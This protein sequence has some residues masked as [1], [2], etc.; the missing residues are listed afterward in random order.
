QNYGISGTTLIHSLLDGHPQ[1]LTLPGLY[2]MEAY[3]VWKN[4][5]GQTEEVE[6]AQYDVL[7]NHFVTTRRHWFDLQSCPHGLDRLGEE[8]DIRLQIPQEFFLQTM[9]AYCGDAERV[10]R[11]DFVVSLFCVFNAHYHRSVADH[12]LLV[13]P[14]HSQPKANMALLRADFS[15]I[16][17]LHMVREPVQNIGSLIKHVTV[18]TPETRFTFAKGLLNCAFWQVLMEKS[19]HWSKKGIRVYGKMPY[20]PDAPHFESRALKLE[21]IHLHSRESMEAL[22]RWLHLDWNDSLLKSE[23]MGY[24]WHNRPESVEQRGLGTKTISQ[25][26]DKYLN[27]F[28]KWRLDLFALKERRY[29]D[30]I[31]DREYNAQWRYLFPLFILLWW[32]FKAEVLKSR[33]QQQC[34][35]GANK[36]K[37]PTIVMAFTVVCRNLLNYVSLRAAMLSKIINILF[38]DEE[39]QYVA[40]LNN[41][42]SPSK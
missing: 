29:F 19:L 32:P 4:I 38:Y 14:I 40:K 2:G 33:F 12:S 17:V 31:N 7:L 34:I 30:Y 1:L 28:D 27:N 36:K 20:F 35:V 16:K 15:N 18:M 41:K 3:D 10:R 23:F 39:K 21:D 37:Y 13:F 26:H 22:C 24:T 6:R 9:T 25:K 8:K 42:K 5:C 11:K